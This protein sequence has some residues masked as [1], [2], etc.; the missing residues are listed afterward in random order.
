MAK[1]DPLP[2][3]EE[4]KKRRR[5]KYIIDPDDVTAKDETRVR[6][7]AKT[8][9]LQMEKESRLDDTLPDKRIIYY[10]EVEAEDID[11][12][13]IY[14]FE[15]LWYM[16]FKKDAFWKL[17]LMHKRPAGN[18]AILAEMTYANLKDA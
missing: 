7:W 8:I 18:Y 6:K 9:M 11:I 16:V 17:R 5:P 2:N 13:N 10:K 3:P 14:P 1:V 4:L 12:K 15:D